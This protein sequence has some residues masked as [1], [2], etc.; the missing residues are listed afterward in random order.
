MLNGLNMVGFVVLK[1]TFSLCY[2]LGRWV[3]IQL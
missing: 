2:A 3:A 1:I